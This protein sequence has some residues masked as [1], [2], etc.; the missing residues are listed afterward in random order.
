MNKRGLSTVVT[1]LIIVMMSLAAVVIVW[2]VIENVIK[3]N[4]SIVDYSSKCLLADVKPES[5][6]Y[7]S[8]TD[9]LTVTLK[10][11]A[12]GGEEASIGG[13]KVSVTAANGTTLSEDSAGNIALLA[14]KSYITTNKFTAKPTKVLTTVYFVKEDGSMYLCPSGNTLSTVA[15]STLCTDLGGSCKLACTSGTEEEVLG[16]TDCTTEALP[17]CC[18]SIGL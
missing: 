17:K 1:T 9:K 7:G 14:T 18:K 15:D 8:G 4:V 2:I 10:R 12:A 3:T 13:V 11:G 16:A 5:A 6:S